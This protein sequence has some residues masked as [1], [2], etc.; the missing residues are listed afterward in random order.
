MIEHIHPFRDGNGRIGRLW[1]T[2]VLSKWNPL[3]AW[4]PIETLVHYNQALYYNALQESHAGDVDCAPFIDCMLDMIENSMYKF[5]DVA[6]E[7]KDG[8]DMR[9]A[10]LETKPIAL[11]D[12]INDPAIDPVNP[13]NDPVNDLVNLIN[14]P[15]KIV[16]DCIKDDPSITYEELAKQIGKS[17]ATVKRCI[18]QLKSQGIISRVGSKKNGRW[19]VV[20]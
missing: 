10:I 16:L 12:P 18:Q 17:T 20:G 13:I 4:T 3:F 1:Q 6:S 8:G 15:V 19:N 11:G 14:D 9:G 5:I 2:L 7:T